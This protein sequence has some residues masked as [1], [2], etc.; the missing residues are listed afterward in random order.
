MRNRVRVLGCTSAYR[1]GHSVT[2]LVRW[3]ARRLASSVSVYDAGLGQSRRQPV[4]GGSDSWAGD[5][6]LLLRRS[7]ASARATSGYEKSLRHRWEVYWV[8]FGIEKLRSGTGGTRRKLESY[9][10]GDQENERSARIR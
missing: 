7:S 3:D 4:S 5:G 6:S 8:R 9:G 10:T 1:R 2:H